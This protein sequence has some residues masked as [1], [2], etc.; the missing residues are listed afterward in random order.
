[1]TRATICLTGWLIAIVGS[2]ASGQAKPPEGWR[3]AIDPPAGA[4]DSILEFSQ[5][6]PGWH[7]TTRHAASLFDPSLSGRG[8][9][10]LETVQ[11]LFPG[12]SQS[13]YG[14]FVGGRNVGHPGDAEY[15]AFLIRRDGHAMIERRAGRTTT[16]LLPWTAVTAIKQVAGEETARNV[17]KVSVGRDSVTFEVNASRVASLARE[18]LPTDGQ[19]GFRTGSDLNLHVTTLDFTTRLAP[20]PARRANH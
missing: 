3:W 17:L 4:V 12:T 10:A 11:I 20:I 1:M 8:S 14:L 2:T 5:M 6:P 16:A 7:I 19:F 9:Y 15:L 18:S 13:G